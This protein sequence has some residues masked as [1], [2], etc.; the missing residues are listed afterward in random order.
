MTCIWIRIW[1]FVCLLSTWIK[2]FIYI[3]HDNGFIFEQCRFNYGFMRLTDS[4]HSK[5]VIIHIKHLHNFTTK[6]CNKI[7][8]KNSIFK[9]ISIKQDMLSNTK[10][11]GGTKKSGPIFWC[12][13][14]VLQWSIRDLFELCIGYT[15]LILLQFRYCHFI[16][17]F[18]WKKVRKRN[19]SYKIT[20]CFVIAL[21]ISF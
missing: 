4:F 18:I 5:F 2:N 7:Y 21:V 9:W 1:F 20:T 16:P 14:M 3:F 6:C 8:W 13:E 17:L 15:D 12:F 10:I 11:P 19:N